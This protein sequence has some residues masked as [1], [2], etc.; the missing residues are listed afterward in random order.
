[1]GG[2]RD[3]RNKRRE[4]DAPIAMLPCGE[5]DSQGLGCGAMTVR[6]LPLEVVFSLVC[7]WLM[8]VAV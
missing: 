7:E 4:Q 8:C 2:R 5:R 3:K 6:Q 1:M